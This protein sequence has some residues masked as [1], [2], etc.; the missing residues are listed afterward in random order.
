MA[1]KPPAIHSPIRP[2]APTGTRSTRPR[3]AVEPVAAWRVNSVAG[4]WAHGPLLPHGEIDTSERAGL[5]ACRTSRPRPQPASAPGSK[6]S[7]ASCAVAASASTLSRPAAL[8]RSAVMLRFEALRC[9]KSAPSSPSPR[10]APDADQR[11]SGSPPWGDSTLTTSAPASASSFVQYG[12][13]ICVEKS[14]T[15]SPA[16]GQ[17]AS[18]C[19]VFPPRGFR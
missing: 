4:R 7:M 15:R 3:W 17:P 6:L 14:I 1:A 13:A 10:V 19:I 5:R 18:L 9:W 11:R 16:R 12:P 8:A 2:P